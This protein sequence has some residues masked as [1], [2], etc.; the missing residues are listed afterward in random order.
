VVELR[1]RFDEARNIRL[2]TRLQ[3]AGANVVYGVVGYKTHA[4]MLLVVRRERGR[5]RRYVHLGTGNYHPGTARAYT[6]F[7]LLSSNEA[8]GEDVHAIFNELTGLGKCG[9]LALLLQAPF[10]LHRALLEAIE[11]EAAEA[12]AGREARII[13]K[14]NALS[15]PSIIAAL[16]RASRAGVEIDLIVRGICRLR[17]GVPGVSESIRVRS[18]L[19]RFLEHSRIFYFHASGAERVYLASAD[20][21]ERNL[22][23]RLETCFPVLDPVLRARVIEEGLEPYLADDRQAWL[24]QPDG[25]YVQASPADAAHP[26]VAQRDLLERLCPSAVPELHADVAEEGDLLLDVRSQERMAVE[27]AI[28]E[29][30]LEGGGSAA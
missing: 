2:A 24:L 27:P 21:M 19:G 30:D 9:E 14:M 20:W 13:A 3:D 4:K 10:T 26:R 11:H 5:L 6:D 8:L 1:A 17:P 25:S 22:A 29:D 12:E 15:E 28:G 7:G 16:Y 18:I 23:R